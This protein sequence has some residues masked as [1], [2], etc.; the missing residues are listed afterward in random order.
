MDPKLLVTVILYGPLFGAIVAGL[1]GR[2]IG[3]TASMAITTGFLIVKSA[4]FRKESRGLHFNTDY[5]LKS[6]LVQ[7]TVL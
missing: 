4:Q 6:S 1:F 2:R 3:N 5:P 7:N